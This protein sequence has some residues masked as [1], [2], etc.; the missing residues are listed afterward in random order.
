MGKQRRKRGNYAERKNK[1]GSISRFSIPTIKGKPKWVKIPNL[2]EYEGKRGAQ[3]HLEWC[4]KEYG[5]DWTTDT[6]MQASRRYLARIKR[7]KHTTYT[8][9]EGAIRLHL[10]PF[11]RNKPIA[12]IRRHDVQVFIDAQIASGQNPNTVRSV[13]IATLSSIFSRYVGEELLPRNPASGRPFFDYGPKQKIKDGR[14]LSTAEG[15][16][17]LQH[18]PAALW[19][20]FVWMMYSGMRIGEVLAMTWDQLDI[21][22]DEEGQPIVRY[23]VEH[24][25]N[26]RLLKLTAPKTES[27]IAD[28]YLPPEI[29]P[30]IEAQRTQVAEARLKVGKDW[31]DLNLVWPRMPGM[32]NVEKEGSKQGN[33]ASDDG[34]RMGEPLRVCTVRLVCKRSAQRAGIG[35]MTLHDLRHTC[36]SLL[37]SRNVNIKIVSGHLRHAKTLTTWDTY[38]HLYPHD[39]TEAARQLGSTFRAKTG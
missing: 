18:T 38:G 26:H 2:P 7:G 32:Y 29:I 23:S 9:R 14:A 15:E 36:A 13:T 19:P 35:E 27:S 8:T 20:I 17:L 37:I 21:E 4:R 3:R 33:N 12:S 5:H 16:L 10:N 22:K 39:Q 31:L 24:T 6:F 34:M 1:D 25:L 28:I 30:I 11:F